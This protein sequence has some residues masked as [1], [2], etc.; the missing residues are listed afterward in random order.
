M[1]HISFEPEI[2]QYFC[3]KCTRFHMREAGGG[4]TTTV[5]KSMDCS[6]NS[7]IFRMVASD[8]RML[9]ADEVYEYQR[10]RENPKRVTLLRS[11]YEIHP[12]GPDVVKALGLDDGTSEE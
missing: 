11:D 2:G 10:V 12:I 3:T 4:F 8:S 1:S 6:Y 5:Y 7:S 9:V